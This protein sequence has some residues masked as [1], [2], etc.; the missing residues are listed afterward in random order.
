MAIAKEDILEAVSSMSVLELNE[1]VKA[2][3]EKFG[4]SAAAVAV[5]GPAGGGAAAAAEEQTE[6][7]VNLTE[8][9][10]NK[11]SVIKAVRELTGLGLKEAKDLVDGAPKPVKESVPKA[12]AEEAKKKLEEAGAKAEIK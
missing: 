2:F 7:T 6:F 8:V 12:A 5:A 11:V 9:G 4:V 3:E 1:L 10:A